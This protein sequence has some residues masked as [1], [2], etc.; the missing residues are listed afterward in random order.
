MARPEPKEDDRRA[1]LHRLERRGSVVPEAETPNAQ[2]PALPSRLVFG[3]LAIFVIVALAV[4]APWSSEPQELEVASTPSAI[5]FDEPSPATKETEIA[6]SQPGAQGTAAATAD[7]PTQQQTIMVNVVG[8]VVNPGVHEVEQGARVKDVIEAAGGATEK[9]D[10]TRLNLAR[11]VNDEEYLP[12]LAPGED[13]PEVLPPSTGSEPGPS[14]SQRSG[15]THAGESGAVLNLNSASQ[16][17]LETLPGVGPVMAG[18]IVDWREQH[19]GFRSVDELREASGIGPKIF[20]Q[21]EP[22]VTV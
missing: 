10:L 5:N 14:S 18:R 19:D 7:E 21:L 4:W 13:V 8:H 3:I 11:I 22:L 17:E 1:V 2:R 15:D 12:V 6:P 20:A 9:A 16:S